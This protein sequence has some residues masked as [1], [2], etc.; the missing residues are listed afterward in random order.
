MTEPAAAPTPAPAPASGGI[1]IVTDA[2]RLVRALFSPGEV[3]GEIRERP[4]FWG[5]WIVVSILFILTQYLLG[6]YQMR[7]QELALAA[8]GR[9]M[10]AAMAKFRYV[11]L[12]VTPVIVLVFAAIGAGILWLG[13]MVTGEEGP[14]KKLLVVT[15][16]TWPAAIIH[17]LVTFAVLRMRGLD[18]VQAASDLQ[19]AL[20]LD[21]LLPAETSRFLTAFA[22]G[23]NP[24]GIWGVVISA[25]GL[26]VL[27]K[28]PSGKAWT[29]AIA[30]FLINLLVGASL[31]GLFGGMAGG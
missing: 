6:P 30:A 11:G 24:F 27:L 1:P 7:V 13:V 3:F 31:A 8:Q 21:L 25:V 10:P 29:I 26:Q 22:G 28:L 23:V 19:V 2:V 4:T 20:G 14:F 16:F 12:A 15:I 17:Q 9:E 18:A 5:P